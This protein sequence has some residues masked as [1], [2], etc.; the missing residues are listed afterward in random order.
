VL[1]CPMAEEM[2]M[3]NRLLY[4]NLQDY[5]DWQ[6]KLADVGTKG[7]TAVVAETVDVR[8]F[9]WRFEG[10]PGHWGVTIYEMKVLDIISEMNYS[11]LSVG[12]TIFVRKYWLLRFKDVAAWYSYLGAELGI[13][14][15]NWEEWYELAPRSYFVEIIPEVG[16]EYEKLVPGHVLP[17][18]LEK[19]YA[20]LV[21][22]ATCK[23]EDYDKLYYSDVQFEINDSQPVSPEETCNMMREKYGIKLD[24]DIRRLNMELYEI[25]PI[26]QQEN[27]E[28][29]E[30]ETSLGLAPI[31]AAK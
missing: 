11:G 23:P 1:R 16:I 30:N 17:M 31:E 9:A 3:V 20:T 8:F 15:S 10:M 27:A 19:T 13:P 7:A 18:Q 29:S 14:A 21:Y 12:D 26:W 2:T 22:Q 5:M 4:E 28:S 25:W 24:M 6:L